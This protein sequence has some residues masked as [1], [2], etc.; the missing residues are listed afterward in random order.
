MEQIARA[1]ERAKGGKVDATERPSAPSSSLSSR[2]T[3]VTAAARAAKAPRLKLREV[4]LDDATL[5]ASRVIAHDIDNPMRKS[6]DILRTQVLQAMDEKEFQLLAVTSPRA[7]CGK[8]VTAIN[9]ALSVARQP[10]RAALLIDMDL[11]KP[12]IANYLGIESDHGLLSVLAGQLAPADAMIEAHVRNQ[13]FLT[14]LTEDETPDSS[15]WMA[16]QAMKTFLQNI[17]RDFPSH[18]VILD[19]P[20]MLMSD[21]VAAILPQIDC[22]LFVAAVGTSTMSDIQDCS[23]HLQSTDVVRIVV[24]KVPQPRATYSSERYY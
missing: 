20:P 9:L 23:R 14:L 2:A 12:R 21:D 18:T 15:V 19:L 24:N 4:A 7:G 10:G 6:I 5:E 22:V 13:R 16:S 8:T 1:I 11:Q 17:R 3:D